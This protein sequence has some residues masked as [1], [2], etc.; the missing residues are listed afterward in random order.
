[1]VERMEYDLYYLEN[2]SLGFDLKIL[3]K[4]VWIILKGRGI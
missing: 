4:T 2:R 3:L 1:M